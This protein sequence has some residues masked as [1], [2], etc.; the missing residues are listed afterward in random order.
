MCRRPEAFA[1][2][3]GPILPRSFDSSSKS[4]PHHHDNFTSCQPRAPNARSRWVMRARPATQTLGCRGVVAARAS[5]MCL[6]GA[7]FK[8]RVAPT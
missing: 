3:C 8:P 4:G 6:S 7:R 5:R 1:K 2:S